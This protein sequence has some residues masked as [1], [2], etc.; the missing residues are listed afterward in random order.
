VEL[1][2]LGA[3]LGEVAAG[4]GGA[5]VVEAEPGTGKSRLVREALGRAGSE[6]VVL[7]TGFSSIQLPG[8]RPALAE[9]FRQVVPE[10]P[11][12]QSAA[13]RALAF[14]GPEAEAQRA[15]I[16]GLAH[17]ADPTA[18]EGRGAGGE[19]AAAR[20]ERWLALAALLRRA[21]A[22]RRGVLVWIE[23]VHWMDEGTQEFLDFLAPRL[24]EQA[25]GLLLTSRPRGPG[26]WLPAGAERLVLA[27][28]DAAAAEEMLGAM[29][30][31]LA[32]EERRELI[33]RAAG[34]PLFIEELARAAQEA[35]A[36]GK[37]L[38]ALPSS[39]QGLLV[40]RIDRLQPPVRL[41]LQMGAI[42]GQRFPTRLLGRMYSLESATL[43]FEPALGA[44]E[45]GGFLE[46]ELNGEAW[47]RFHHA[48]VQE[49]AYGGLLVR[50]RKILHESA[51]RLGEEYYADRLQAEAAFFAHHYWEAGLAEAAGPHLWTAGREAAERYELAAAERFLS[52]VAQ[53]LEGQPELFAEAARRAEFSQTFGHV[54]LHRGALEAA[55]QR[56][57]ELEELGRAAERGDWLARG[58][59]HRGRVAWYRGRL[60]E[61]R[62]LFE[63]GLERVPKAEEQIAADLHNDLGIV[64][65]Y[66]GDPDAAFSHHDLALRLRE[67][68]D[69][70]LGL[71]KSHS[72]LGN[73]LLDFRDDLEGAEE[74]YRRALELARE[75]GARE[76]ITSTLNNLGGVATERGKW[77][78]AMNWF[79]EATR[80]QEEIGWSF[81]GYVTL[82]NQILCEIA[83]GRIA[84]AL[85]HLR[86]CLNR[87][88]AFLEPVN[89]VRTRFLF[90]D[91]YLT[92][93]ADEQAGTWLDDARRLAEEL[94]VG[95]IEDEL[96]L[97]EGR[98]LAARGDWRG[99]E[100]AFGGA[101][102]AAAKLTHPPF[103]TLARAQRSR[104][105]ARAGDQPPEHPVVES[106]RRPPLAALIRY[107]NADA[108]REPSPE[109]AAE[110]E[111]AG[112]EAAGL[113]DVSL[114]RAAFERAGDVWR[115]LGNSIR[116]E[117]A[118]ARAAA[119]LEALSAG[120][121][122]DLR[123]GFLAD[124][125]NEGLRPRS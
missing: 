44:L 84:D 90:F 51:A 53:V 106:A 110:L 125:R 32:P 26:A 83:L 75:I 23:D 69:D 77:Q 114:E 13:E 102:A 1:E 76:M 91:A 115:D 72:N 68:L 8:Q 78:E 37:P 16:E 89:R 56:F 36:A 104:A 113:G 18:P 124:P 88:D 50:L 92:A 117:K 48:L 108:E 100:A 58:L 118:L 112:E 111:R 82:Q 95:E 49:A 87:G 81:L 74:R 79:R 105:A 42:L 99:A 2:Q 7:E 34:N 24:G 19:A 15:G 66:R 43:G 30:A 55:E 45:A 59:E 40:S 63:Q 33:G 73:L 39:L 94:E 71:A 17:E 35:A 28:L 41:L 70:R 57:R 61:A 65:Y 123:A 11:A 96:A 93:L 5:L 54:L 21:A 12:G 20:Q 9:L 29:L 116:E 80:L 101:E 52:R 103:E 10:A 121:P 46:P 6:L 107:L 109:V 67:R 38:S 97:R 22:E 27:P 31:D 120:L 85:R 62:T 4:R 47:H 3:F 60:D 122:E 64:F 119:A 25:L 14:L 98:R 86:E